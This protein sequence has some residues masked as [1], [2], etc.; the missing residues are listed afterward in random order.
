MLIRSTRSLPPTLPTCQSP[1]PR[2]EAD[3]ENERL[4]I[5][6]RVAGYLLDRTGDCS[7]T[8][9]TVSCVPPRVRLTTMPDRAE[10][11]TERSSCKGI[12]LPNGR[13]ARS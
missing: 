4:T 11:E 9:T 7:V 3:R 8:P 1:S 2:R 6:K 12:S 13:Q 5:M 10:G